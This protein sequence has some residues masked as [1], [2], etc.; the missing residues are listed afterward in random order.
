MKAESQERTC[1]RAGA[2]LGGLAG[3]VWGLMI[4]V[5]TLTGAEFPNAGSIGGSLLAGGP[6]AA[7]GALIGWKSG[8]IVGRLIMRA[9]QRPIQSVILGAGLGAV[10]GAVMLG[11]LWG[12]TFA[13][14]HAVDAV[15][16]GRGSIA[17]IT[18]GAVMMGSVIGGT[19]GAVLGVPYGL[20]V[21]LVM[22]YEAD[23]SASDA[24]ASTRSALR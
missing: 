20:F 7:L 23:P 6:L 11:L 14:A 3:S 10:A 5:G 16:F 8:E 12:I 15:D 18:I 22:K 4:I 21:A 1:T 9:R 19:I 24:G 17:Q 13:V 2:A